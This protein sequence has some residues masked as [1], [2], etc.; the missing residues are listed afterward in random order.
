VTQGPA[1][2]SGRGRVLAAVL[3]G[4][5]GA[6][7]VVVWQATRPDSM[8]TSPSMGMSPGLFLASWTVM[9]A[10]MMLPAAL[11][12]LLTFHRIQAGRGEQLRAAPLTGVFLT[13]YLLVWTA[14]GAV[15]LGARKLLESTGLPTDGQIAT[16]VLLVLAGAYQLSPLKHAC[17]GRCR[18]PLA[19]LLGSWRD[20]TAGALRMGLQHGLD[21][22]GC[23]WPLFLLLFPLGL[24]NLP[25]MVAVTALVFAEKVLP[26]GA[27]LARAAGAGLIAW[28]L[29]TLAGGSL[30][31]TGHAGAPSS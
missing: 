16:G 14:F 10:A 29:S 25:A 15:A 28:G 17:L 3:V 30:P 13:A 1:L 11:P 31:S 22:L 27:T 6:W 20:G 2:A 19:F 24:M 12:V 26:A 4:A 21:C 8:G 23:C 18:T 5:L 7:A 9:M